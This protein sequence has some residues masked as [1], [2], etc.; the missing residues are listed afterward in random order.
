MYDRYFVRMAYVFRHLPEPE[1][2]AKIWEALEQVFASL[3]VHDD[4][5]LAARAFRVAHA[6]LV[7]PRAPHSVRGAQRV[8][9]TDL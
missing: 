9:R 3:H 7:Q 1:A 4:T 6:S 5:P 2:Q 8:A